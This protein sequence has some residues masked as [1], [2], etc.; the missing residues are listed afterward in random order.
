MNT[1]FVEKTDDT[2]RLN[3]DPQKKIFQIA[4][5][6]MPDN[7]VKFYQPAFDW[8]NKFAEVANENN[9]I[10]LEV[11]FDYFNTAS[12]KIFLDLLDEFQKISEAGAAVVVEWN[13]R[14]G[15][16]DMQEAGQEYSEMID[17]P[18]EFKEN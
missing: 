7:P 14:K 1:F 15:D 16:E 10:R 2:P 9:N 11:R 6:S 17:I 3:F 18:F 5:K 8:L 12:S 4:G 13:Y